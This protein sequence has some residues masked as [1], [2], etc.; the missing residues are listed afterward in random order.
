MQ[1]ILNEALHPI[2][3]RLDRLAKLT[4]QTARLSTIVT[5]YYLLLL[6]SYFLSS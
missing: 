5:V 6:Y 1:Q 4:T 2:T 3:K